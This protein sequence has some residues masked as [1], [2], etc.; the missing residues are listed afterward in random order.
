MATKAFMQT[1]SNGLTKIGSSRR[2]RMVIFPKTTSVIRGIA[3][4]FR[5]HSVIIGATPNPSSI[6][7][8]KDMTSGT[9][10]NPYGEKE[11]MLATTREGNQSLNPL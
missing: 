7:T 4:N 1:K 10:V 3:G 9:P 6:T 11:A 8:L 2:R 5:R